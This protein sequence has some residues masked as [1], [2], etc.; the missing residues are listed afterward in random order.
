[1]KLAEA[2]QERSDLNKKI[3]Q[4]KVRITNNTTVQEGEETSEDPK[5]LLNEFDECTDRLEEL[6][7]RI[8]LTNC[9]T[10]VDG[11]SL[12]ELIARKDMLTLSLSSYRDFVNSASQ[13]TYRARRTEIKIVS[14]INVKEMQKS[15]DIMAKELRIIDNKIQEINWKT[16]LE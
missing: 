5:E 13:L 3:E 9:K 10:I 2:L 12:T 14:T 1:M 16:E 11:K 7:A 8:N 6:I 4:L 15:V